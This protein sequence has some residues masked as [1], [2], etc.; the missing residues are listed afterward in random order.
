MSLRKA[1]FWIQAPLEFTFRLKPGNFSQGLPDTLT[2]PSSSPEQPFLGH[3][4]ADLTLPC[5]KLLP[6]IQPAAFWH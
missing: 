5:I 6:N 2:Y 4:I 1:Q 3:S